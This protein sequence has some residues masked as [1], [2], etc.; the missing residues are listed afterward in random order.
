ME[1]VLSDHPPLLAIDPGKEKCG[2]AVVTV[3]RKVLEKEIVALADLHLR[4]SYFIGKYGITTIVLGDRTGARETRELLRGGGLNIEI[5]FVNEDR[6]SELGRVRYLQANPPRGW[7]RLL[8]L[9]MRC[10][11]C[12]Y[13]DYVAVILAE[14]YL[15]GTRSTRQ[16]HGEQRRQQRTAA[17]ASNNAKR[18]E[19]KH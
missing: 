10:P 11:N 1:P 13:D 9:S 8:P 7:H 16:R 14:R 3:Q 18:G 5:I 6:S 2:I 15:D 12:A 4:I 17:G 19:F